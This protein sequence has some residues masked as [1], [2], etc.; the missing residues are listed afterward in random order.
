MRK[1]KQIARM[2]NIYRASAGAGKTHHL[3]G[4]FLKF[5]FRK[6]YLPENADHETQFNEI[7]AVT[8]TNKSTA[9]MKDRI[10][11]ELHKLSVDPSDSHYI[12]DLREDGKGGIQTDE[13]VSKKARKFLTDILNNYSDFAIST[14]D[15]FFQKIVRS[16]ARELNLQSNYEIELNADRIIK[17]AVSSFL[18]KLDEKGHRRQFNWMR[19]FSDKKL[20]EGNSWSLEN[21]L[22]QLASSVLLKEEYRVR[23]ESLKHIT[24]DADFL[25]SYTDKA[26]QIERNSYARIKALGKEGLDILREEG[27][28]TTDFKGGKTGKMRILEKWEAGGFVDLDETQQGFAV[29]D[30]DWY[31]APKNKSDF[32]KTLPPD[33]TI[34]LQNV[35]AEAMELRSDGFFTNYHTAK[36]ILENIYQLGILAD[37]DEEVNKICNEEGSMLL[38]STTE[39][40][41]KLIT[42]DDAPFIYEKIGTRIFSFMIDEFQDTSKMQWENFK[43]LIENSLAEGRGNLIVGDVKQSIYRWRGSDWNLLYKGL[44]NFCPEL[45]HEDKDTLDTNYRSQ[46]NIIEFNNAFFK[47]A[48]SVL[49][50]NIDDLNVSDIF[51]DVSQKVPKDKLDDAPGLVKAEFIEV[52][53]GDKFEDLAMERLPQAIMDLEDAG[54]KAKDIA[55]LCRTG[56]LCKKAADTLLKFKTEGEYDSHYVFDIISNEAL[57]L[58]SRHIIQTILSIF[59]YIQ[60]PESKILK[61]IASLNYLQQKGLSEQEAVTTYF[62]V[63]GGIETFLEFSNRPLYDMLE[64]IISQLPNV[65]EDMAFVQAFRDCVMDFANSKRSSLSAFLEWWELNSEKKCINTPEGQNA[66]QIL[67]IH[68]SKGLGMPAVILPFC[69]GTVDIETKNKKNI[70]WCHPNK[71]PFAVDDLY[72][73]ITLSKSLQDTIFAK[74]FQEERLRAV[75]DNLNTIYVAYTRAKEALVLFSPVPKT[76]NNSSKSEVTQQSLLYNFAKMSDAVSDNTLVFG[77]LKRKKDYLKDEVKVAETISQDDMEISTSRKIPRLSLKHDKMIK[78][79]DAIEKGNCI[80]DALAVIKDSSDIEPQISKLY[81]TGKLNDSY[82]SCEDMKSEIARL[83]ALPDVR[84][85][86]KPGLKVLNEKT[87]LSKTVLRGGRIKEQHRP[88]R[89]IIDND[90]VIVIDYKTGEQQ[91][92]HYTQVRE[93]M[94]FLSQ[95]GFKNVEGYIWYIYPHEIKPVRN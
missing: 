8:F 53:K 67:T 94:R 61:A 71:E 47:Y 7:L 87:I 32:V 88:D 42:I 35:F 84:D 91:R 51:S 4:E 86:F 39:L 10:I 80:H 14:I 31:R 60:N 62:S 21:D 25:N 22:I 58:S 48:A 68:K 57:L 20:E 70:I 52:E 64:G 72:L 54:F 79:I 55:I 36:A 95:M 85:W 74:D 27:F 65:A 93:Y 75:I 59:K 78:E 23:K 34:R 9:E 5:L 69:E 81:K 92:H 28:T 3:T 18:D 73:P 24:E 12:K 43:P 1:T 26:R 83:I 50:A 2:L 40:L 56:A 6:D 30:K 66:I 37:I 17:T 33:A 63:G 16:F 41:N 11:K 15:S 49:D 44:R 46:Q 77:E 90:R 89:I 13:E 29:S 45:S 38:S 82:L 19:K 76:S